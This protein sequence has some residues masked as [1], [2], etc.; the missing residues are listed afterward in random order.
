MEIL[1]VF[2]EMLCELVDFLAQKG[3]LDLR[4]AGVRVVS[5]GVFDRRR[6]FL[7]SKHV[8]ALYHTLIIYASVLKRSPVPHQGVYTQYC[9]HFE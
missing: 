2:L 5:G 9:A 6:L 3:N 4:G 8:Q 1:V 7:C